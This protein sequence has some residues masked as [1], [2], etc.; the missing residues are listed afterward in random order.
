M[1]CECR[2]TILNVR[3]SG[4]SHTTAAIRSSTSETHSIVTIG[5]VEKLVEASQ[6]APRRLKILVDMIDHDAAQMLDRWQ[7]DTITQAVTWKVISYRASLKYGE[8]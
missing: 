7:D 2:A 5:R 3:S 4:A 8:S 1:L 6:N